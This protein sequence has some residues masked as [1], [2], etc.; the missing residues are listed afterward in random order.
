MSRSPRVITYPGEVVS[1][2]W[3]KNLCIHAAECGRAKNDLFETG[4][5]PWCDP[6]LVDEAAVREVV[7]RCPSGALSVSAGQVDTAGAAGGTDASDRTARNT[8]TVSSDGPLF[9]AG[10]L[11]IADAPE[12]APG[13]AERAA[14]CRCGLSGNKPYCDNGHRAGNWREH[15]A[16]GETGDAD[17]SDE[18]GTLSVEVMKDG[19]LRVSGPMTMFSGAAREAWHGDRTVL[20]RCGLSGRKPFCDGSHRKQGWSDES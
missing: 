16:I 9:L 7:A 4:R 13:L 12:R 2:A 17:P 19:P 14:L 6:S 5:D 15:G 20:C 18:G 3:D 8:I 10:Q 11:D 1:V